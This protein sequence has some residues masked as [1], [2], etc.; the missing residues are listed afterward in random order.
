[1]RRFSPLFLALAATLAAQPAAEE[2]PMDPLAGSPEPLAAAIRAYGRDAGRWAYTQHIIQYDRK[3]RVEQEQLA[4]F[5]PSQHYDVQWTLLQQNGKEATESQAKKFR[6]ERTKMS[7]NRRTLG[8]LLVL[9]EAK[10]VREDDGELVYEVPL[11]KDD[12]NRLPPEKFEVLVT[13]N[14]GAQTL[15]AID[16]QL[17]KSWRVVGVVNVKSGEAHLGFETVKPE[18]GPTVTRIVGEGRATI[19]LVPV[20]AKAE[21]KRSDFKRVTPYDERFNVKIG[22]LKTID[23]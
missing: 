13:L 21:V 22:P 5:D 3:G 17:K 11:K 18:H 12:N 15:R 20:G 14:R 19:L 10:L 6:K 7:G 9:K 1:M 23:F 2:D 4:R 16:V 8:E